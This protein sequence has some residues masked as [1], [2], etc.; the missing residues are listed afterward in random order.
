[1]SHSP[2]LNTLKR[3]NIASFCVLILTEFTYKRAAI[4]LSCESL[5]SLSTRRGSLRSVPVLASD[6]VSCNLTSLSKIVIVLKLWTRDHTYTQMCP[7]C[8]IGK[9]FL[10]CHLICAKWTTP[11]SFFPLNN[12]LTSMKFYKKNT[13][14][15]YIF[16]IYIFHII[17]TFTLHFFYICFV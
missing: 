17:I 7:G 4:N 8:K 13:L 16:F 10:F 2:F 5:S 14:Y 11:L 9:I 1:M 6:K 3:V 15:L 12:P